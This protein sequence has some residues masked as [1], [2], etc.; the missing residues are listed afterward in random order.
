M[1]K[2]YKSKNG[3]LVLYLPNEVINGMRLKEDDEVDFFGTSDKTF[4]FAKKSDIGNMLMGA[5]KADE[6]IRLR[7]EAPRGY[8]PSAEELSVLKKIDTLR[9]ENRTQENTYR[10]LNESERRVLQSLIAHGAVSQFKGKAGKDLYSIPK[11]IYDNFLMR[12]KPAARAEPYNNVTPQVS[13]KDPRDENVVELEKNGFL[14]LQT[15]AEASKVSLLLEQSIRHGQVLGT[16]SFSK[17]REFYIMLR[18]YFDRYAQ[19]L[20]KKL[21]EKSSRVQDLAKELNINEDGARAIL[22]I[23]AENGDVM[24]KKKETFTIA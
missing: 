24:E 13:S 1:V 17:N 2:I 6:P 3:K 20:L 22:Y 19:S 14:V 7:N 12:K 11:G 10:I 9:Y 4:V 23:L 16:R 21:R 15:E 18:S 8:A 5:P